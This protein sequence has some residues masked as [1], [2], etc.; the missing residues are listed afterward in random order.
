MPDNDSVESPN[1]TD[2]AGVGSRKAASLREAGFES[3]RDVSEAS[4]D[5]LTRADGVGETL[6]ADIKES[7]VKL[8]LDV[9]ESGTETIVSPDG[10][11]TQEQDE[12][13]GEVEQESDENAEREAEEEVDE[14]GES[15]EE[16]DETGES[17]EETEET[18]FEKIRETTRDL[19]ETHLDDPFEGI[20]EI[21][22]SD[23]GWFAVVEVIERSAVPD[24]QDIIGRYE[25]DFDGTGLI[26]SYR[27]TDRYRRGSV[28]DSPRW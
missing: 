23:D 10:G 1:V 24:T 9:S 8:G 20:I 5:E 19:A 6:A 13:E 27:L 3:V 16:V 11:Q 15:E 21:D 2:I 7:A 12:T 25:M 28:S 26:T 22:R 17:E 4:I 14:T 18:D